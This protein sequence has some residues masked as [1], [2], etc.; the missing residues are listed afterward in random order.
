MNTRLHLML[1]LVAVIAA[2]PLAAET[3]DRIIVPHDI[4]LENDVECADCHDGIESSANAFETH[5]PDMDVCADCHDVDEDDTC[6][7]CHTDEDTAGEWVRPKFGALLFPHA[8]HVEAGMDCAECHGDLSAGQPVI[9]T[10]AQCR[11]CHETADNY[12]DC[13]M[14]HA[15]GK[16]LVPFDHLAGW[17][18][19]HGV[20]ARFDDQS[21]SECHGPST[22]QECH[23]GD[24]IEPMVHELG[25]AYSHA[26]QAR[27]HEFECATCHQEPEGCVAC[28]QAEHVLPRN[29]QRA[30][31]LSPTNGGAH[32]VEGLFDIENCVACHDTGASEPACAQCHGG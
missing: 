20:A 19:R 5:F 4:H 6:A 29:H 3:L 30:D 15:A 1:S 23:S 21:C 9:P 26:L 32:A 2:T 16:G 14:C 22:C 11:E 25:F 12:A 10:K 17:D 8:A 18:H 27:G 31:W 7:S 28:H 13:R 24:N